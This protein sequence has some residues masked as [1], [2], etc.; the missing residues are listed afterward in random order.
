M[1]KDAAALNP[2]HARI[3][4]HLA[5][6]YADLDRLDEAGFA[7]TE[8]LEHNPSLSASSYL[9]SHPFHD[10]ERTAWYKDLLLRAGLPEY[11]PGAAADK[12]SV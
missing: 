6:V 8:A 11:S 7:A 5:A 12:P 9:E 2:N 3:Y 10:A 1:Y 4:V